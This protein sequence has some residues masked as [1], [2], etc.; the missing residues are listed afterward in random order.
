MH[1]LE[2][3][4]EASV[5]KVGMTHPLPIDAI[6]QFATGA[7]LCVA[8]EEGD[9]YLNEALRVAGIPVADRPESFR[10]G[11]LNVNRVRH[12]LAGEAEPQTVPPRGKPPQ[13]CEGCPHRTVFTILKELDCIVA[14]DIGC[15]TLAALP[16]LQAMDT[17]ICMGASIGVGLGMRHTLPEAS[18][19]RVVSVIGDST[20]LHSGVTGLIEMVYNPP[21]NGHVVLVL[22]NGTTAMTGLQEHPGTG[23]SLDHSRAGKVVPETLATALGVPNVQVFNPM[24]DLDRLR[25]EIRR[26]LDSDELSVFVTRQPCILAAAKIRGYEK[27][28]EVTLPS[29]LPG[30]DCT[31][32]KPVS[33]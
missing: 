13:L 11:E 14:G 24:R 16:P 10:F 26:A 25:E 12:L 4:P 33:E 27:A 2:A 22:D 3:A 5:F 29:I 6:R 23:R 21:V 18:A 31:G 7:A 20:F 32:E 15:Y 8:V 17:Q 28:I 19:R 1:V 9:P 30:C